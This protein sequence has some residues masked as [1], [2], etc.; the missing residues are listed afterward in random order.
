MLLE[1]ASAWGMG[2]YVDGLHREPSLQ[3]SGLGTGKG[4]VS[5]SMVLEV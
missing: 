2:S 4:F 1:L 5:D 3:A